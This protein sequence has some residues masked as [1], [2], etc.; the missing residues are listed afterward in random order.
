MFYPKLPT[1]LQSEAMIQSIPQNHLI[2]SPAVMW[3]WFETIF[4]AHGTETGFSLAHL[5]S[6]LHSMQTYVDSLD[7]QDQQWRIRCFQI[8]NYM[9]MMLQVSLSKSKVL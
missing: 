9:A 3:E 8:V 2:P 1:A 6:L 7:G 5:R 4:H